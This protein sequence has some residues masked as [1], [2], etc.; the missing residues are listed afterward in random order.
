MNNLV[1]A[2]LRL[3]LEAVKSA[4]LA[5]VTF[6]NERFAEACKIEKPSTAEQFQALYKRVSSSS[7][8]FEEYQKL[9]N[10]YGCIGAQADSYLTALEKV[11]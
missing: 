10:L 4:R 7:A 2:D 9:V 1:I 11:A 6:I 3:T 8:A 5:Y